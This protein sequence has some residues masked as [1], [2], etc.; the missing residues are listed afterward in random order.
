MNRQG[1]GERF[2]DTWTRDSL[3]IPGVFAL[4]ERCN[5]EIFTFSTKYPILLKK[6]AHFRAPAGRIEG[7]ERVKTV[8]QFKVD[9]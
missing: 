8:P 2:R 4:L 6:G 1:G 5:G 3:G 7:P 9:R